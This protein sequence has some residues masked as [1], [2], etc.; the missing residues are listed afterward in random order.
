M[1]D[2]K[3]GDKVNQMK[4]VAMDTL[5]IVEKGS[6]L[7]SKGRWVNIKEEC[8]LAIDDTEEYHPNELDKLLYDSSREILP[9]T[10]ITEV[11]EE[12]TQV[13]AYRLSREGVNDIAA[14]N[15]ASAK[16]PGGGF[17]WGATAQEE[18]VARCSALYSCLE[19]M[20]DFYRTN[21][22]ARTVLY[23]DAIIYSPK[24]PFFRVTA[25]NKNDRIDDPFCAS[26][27]T[28]PAP[29]LSSGDPSMK[30]PSLKVIIRRIGKILAVAEDHGNRNLVLGA[31]GCGVF[32]NDPEFVADVFGMWLENDRFKS[33]FDRVVFG[34]Y[35]PSIDKKS[36]NAFKKRFCK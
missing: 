24:V 20:A 21:R 13:V 14:L 18:D 32:A 33:S 9:K 6:Y 17:I 3:S 4:K 7:N 8:K 12:T 23:T 34:V 15:F 35:D 11:T 19:P 26:I 5:Q 25:K 2:Y 27:I 29:N 31:W 36:Y 1:T 30:K 10:V 22:E 16:N 28:S